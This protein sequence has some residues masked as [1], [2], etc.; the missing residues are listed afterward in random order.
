[1][2]GNQYKPDPRQV[3]FLKNYLDPKSDKFANSYQSAIGAG[4]EHEYAKTI[5]SKDLDWLA[6]SVRDEQM[7]S[8]AEN[9]LR[10]GMNEDYKTDD[11]VDSA[12]MRT[13]M[14]VSKFVAQTLGK[15]KFSSKGEDAANKIADKILGMNVTFEHDTARQNNRVQDE[16]SK[17]TESG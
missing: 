10:K 11:K 15:N 8:L 9:N 2:S 14:D 5:L 12:V 7:I 13:V 3:I 17:A 1:M 6:E 4:Y 16:D